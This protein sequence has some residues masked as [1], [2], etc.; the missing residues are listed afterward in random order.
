[1]LTYVGLIID[2]T[3]QNTKKSSFFWFNELPIK[4]LNSIDPEQIIGEKIKT[5]YNTLGYLESFSFDCRGKVIKD[6][7]DFLRY[8]YFRKFDYR[9]LSLHASIID[10]PKTLTNKYLEKYKHSKRL[11][12]SKRINKNNLDCGHRHRVG[13]KSRS[14]YKNIRPCDDIIKLYD[15][16]SASTEPEIKIKDYMN[17]LAYPGSNLYDAEIYIRE[18]LESENSSIGISQSEKGVLN[19]E[20][21]LCWFDNYQDFAE[22]A[23]QVRNALSHYQRDEPYVLQIDLYDQTENEQLKVTSDILSRIA[24]YKMT[25]IDEW[26]H[27]A[28]KVYQTCDE[29]VIWWHDNEFL[30]DLYELCNGTL[31]MMVKEKR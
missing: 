15:K 26:Y 8:Y 1:M 5:P 6:L 9:Q 19:M 11:V 30:N 3:S 12:E 4:Y 21:S 23:K 13:V 18:T 16:A 27:E 10:I 7:C 29:E 20:T 14:I 25:H 28:E 22:Y 24:E 17:V 31:P 2:T